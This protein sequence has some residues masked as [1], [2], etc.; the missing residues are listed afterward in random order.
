[1]YCLS[2]EGRFVAGTFG[3]LDVVSL[4]LFVSGTYCLSVRFVPW[5]GFV[6]GVFVPLEVLY[7]GRFII[8]RFCL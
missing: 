3:L 7:L 4:A 2:I 6:P 5:D 1:M 8:G